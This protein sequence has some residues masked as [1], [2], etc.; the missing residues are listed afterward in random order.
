MQENKKDFITEGQ[1]NILWSQ[2]ENNDNTNDTE[3]IDK[4]NNQ[5]KNDDSVL[6][7]I[8]QEVMREVMNEA[9]F[10][11]F[12]R[13]D[14]T[15]SIDQLLNSNVEQDG[16]NLHENNSSIFNQS[17]EPE[18]LSESADNDYKKDNYAETKNI[19][20]ETNEDVV[21]L[22]KS[23]LD[24]IKQ[25]VNNVNESSQRINELLNGEISEIG[26]RHSFSFLNKRVDDMGDAVENGK[27]VEGVFNGQ[28]MI[29]PDGKQYNIPSN[30]AS[31]SKLV[32]GDI[33][34]LTISPLGKFI[35][36]QI[37]P[38]ERDR[39][40]GVLTHSNAEF[41]VESDGKKWKI[42]TAS[43]TYFKGKIGDEAIILVPKHGDSTWA[44]VENIMNKS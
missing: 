21:V 39:I 14:E 29:G 31:K 5:L 6:E 26:D 28:Y 23:K 17:S 4:L 25:L 1:N 12:D 2:S 40:V 3:N 35:Y 8:N 37:G 42:L 15:L 11:V 24:L 33:L 9:V 36:K 7:G 32:E 13:H 20:T 38:I 43:V 18:A 22:Q 27:I 34:K 44:A 16:D 41:F 19:E 30:Y 10:G